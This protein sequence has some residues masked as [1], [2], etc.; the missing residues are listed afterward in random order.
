MGPIQAATDTEVRCAV[1]HAGAATP[2]AP[3]VATARISAATR[4]DNLVYSG[5]WLFIARVAGIAILS[6]NTLTVAARCCMLVGEEAGWRHGPAQ[7]TH[8]EDTDLEMSARCINIRGGTTNQD[9]AA[10]CDT[11]TTAVWEWWCIVTRCTPWATLELI[12]P[13]TISYVL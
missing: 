11:S 10:Q 1:Q 8:A 4:E 5:P 6:T 7:S 9:I 3:T 2:N 12:A 13:F